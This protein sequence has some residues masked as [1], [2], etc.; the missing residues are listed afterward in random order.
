MNRSA[1]FHRP[2]P[3]RSASSARARR[4][5]VAP[6]GA[7]V[8]IVAGAAAASA[9][10]TVHSSDATQGGKDT[11]LLFR[12]PNEETKATTT[13]IEIDLPT[14]LPPA[15]VTAAPPAGWLANL[16]Q[17]G[18]I[19]FTGGTISGTDEVDFAIKV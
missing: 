17:P 7:A 3:P 15:G 14:D 13:R 12:V 9:H 19:V 6:V 18:K 16:G 10:I 2:T 5:L 1:S 11:T 4:L 8:L